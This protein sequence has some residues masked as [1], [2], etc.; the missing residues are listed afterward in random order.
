MSSARIPSPLIAGVTPKVPQA[1]TGTRTGIVSRR[2]Y[3]EGQDSM[4][5]DGVRLAVGRGVGNG[6]STSIFARQVFCGRKM[7]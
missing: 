5:K 1:L 6:A 2:Q 4:Q 3:T 7:T